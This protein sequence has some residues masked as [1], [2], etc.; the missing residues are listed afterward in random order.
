MQVGLGIDDQF[1]ENLRRQVGQDL[2]GEQLLKEALR[3][4]AWALDE[5]AHGRVVVSANPQGGELRLLS[6]DALD[7]A[8]AL[9]G[10]LKA[11]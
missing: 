7:R 8:R 5:C 11:G 3:I 1:V 10:A 4:F 6:M 2:S 9:R